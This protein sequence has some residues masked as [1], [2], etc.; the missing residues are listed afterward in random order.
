MKVGVMELLQ[1]KP[2]ESW[3][4]RLYH[5]QFSKQFVRITPQALAVW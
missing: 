3:S 2:A 1:E 4:Y 5:A